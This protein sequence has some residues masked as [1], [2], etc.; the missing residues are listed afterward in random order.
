MQESHLITIPCLENVLSLLWLL[1]VGSLIIAAGSVLRHRGVNLGLAV[2]SLRAN[3][4]LA[5]GGSVGLLI[6]GWAVS[7]SFHVDNEVFQP[8]IVLCKLY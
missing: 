1:S 3:F 7:G 5:A 8:A 6:G 2:R 4:L